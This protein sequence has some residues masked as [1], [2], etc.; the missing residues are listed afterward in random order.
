MCKENYYMIKRELCFC[1]FCEEEH[2]IALIKITEPATIK[3]EVINCEIQTYL[4]EKTNELF[5][6]GAL[7]NANLLLYRDTY[8]ENHGLLT[9]NAIVVIREKFRLTQEEFAIILGLGEKTIAR[10]ETG[11]IQD[12]PY[13]TLMRKF[14]EDYNFAY[15]MLIKAKDKIDSTKYQSIVENLRSL[16]LAETPTRYNDIQLRNLYLMYDKETSENGYRILNVPKIKSMLAYFASFTNQ[17][18]NVKL[19]K[20]FWYSD[21]LSYLKTGKS[22]TG[23]IYLH[24]QHGALP[25][26]WREIGNLDSVNKENVV[27]IDYLATEYTPKDTDEIDESLFTEEELSILHNVCSK[28]KTI[29]GTE[30]SKIMHNEAAYLQTTDRQIIDFSIIKEIKAIAI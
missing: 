27:V 6:D 10:Y 1:P 11:T 3:G 9:R 7:N 17:L 15:D 21:V 25:I 30:L 8:R 28:F 2:E 24:M 14:D 22:M 26:G 4:C 5:E 16:I 13:D 12:R 18:F 19:M 29:T 23:L 20:L